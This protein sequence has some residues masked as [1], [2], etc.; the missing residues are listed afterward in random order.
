MRR[1]LEPKIRCILLANSI[2]RH[3][4]GGKRT[5]CTPPP[6]DAHARSGCEDTGLH[7]ILWRVSAL[8]LE[9][10]IST[11][12]RI[13][14]EYYFDRPTF[15]CCNFLDGNDTFHINKLHDI[16]VKL[17]GFSFLQHFIHASIWSYVFAILQ[18][19]LSRCDL[20]V[21]SRHSIYCLVT[22]IGD[23]TLQV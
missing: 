18:K 15:R 14:E 5:P 7:Q 16:R 4:G 22:W 21:T 17:L 1:R 6:T 8:N 20:T 23:G 12:V 13:G 11:I 19:P 9:N 10:A 3:P 2:W